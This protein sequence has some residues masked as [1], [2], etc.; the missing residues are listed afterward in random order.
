MTRIAVLLFLLFTCSVSHG[1]SSETINTNKNYDAIGEFVSYL[2]E[3]NNPLTLEQAQAA[4]DSGIFSKWQTPVLGFGIGTSP[5]WLHFTVTN[6]GDNAVTRR[7][8]IENSWLDQAD[9]FIIKHGKTISHQTQGDSQPF[10]DKLVN[11]RFFVFDH[12]Y[13]PGVSEVYL[14]AATPDPML[15]P[16]FFGDNEASAT[17]DVINGYGYGLLYGIIIG[18]LLYNLL[19][20]VSIRQ[21]RYFFYVVY[22]L[23][24]LLTNGSYTGH[25]YYLLWPDSVWLQQWINPFAISL[26]AT[27]G[28]LFAFS[29][30][31]IRQLFPS[32]YFKTFVFCVMFWLT[33]IAF[34]LSCKQAA[35]VIVAIAFVS[36]FSIFTFYAAIISLKH[37]HRDAIYYLIATV[38]TLFGTAV[39]AL[40]VWGILPYTTLTYHAAE[41]AIS[42]DAL[43]LSLALAEQIRRAQLEKSQ[44]QQLARSD[45]LTGLNNRRAFIEIST[46]IWH[47][48]IRR[49]QALCLILLD[50]DRFKIINDTHG[51]AIGDLVLKETAAVLDNI[52]R[53][54]DVL[55]RWGGE[56]FAILL[57]QTSIEQAIQIAERIRSSIANIEVTSG[58][59]TINVTASLGVAIKD[60]SVQNIEDLFKVADIYLYQ[61]KQNGR[62]MV[63]TSLDNTLPATES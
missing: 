61:A 62:N 47:N 17:R 58:T 4:Y 12:D 23:M 49:E 24:F 1:Q 11:H 34:M 13:A 8:I 6:A 31:K 21:K 45:M 9:V 55:A 18:L 32:L 14:R 60:D 42:I 52:V 27:S 50:L 38:A 25:G 51:H 59:S 28:I 43:L 15:L 40:T 16:I 35:S 33:Q 46:P 41:I 57:P 5:V 56:E 20:Y 7:L 37:G 26:F 2:A 39:T 48:A 29:F 19:L 53:D 3:T 44:A 63:C 22:L 36:F 54:G 30:L 10:A